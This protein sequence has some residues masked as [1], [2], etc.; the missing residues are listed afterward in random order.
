[1][2]GKGNTMTRANIKTVLPTHRTTDRT[3]TEEM[4]CEW[5][6]ITKVS[7]WVALLYWVVARWTNGDNE[8][9]TTHTFAL[10]A[11]YCS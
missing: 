7:L 8:Q 6:Q 5:N 11:P 1:M 2:L 10:R 9:V 3:H 4:D